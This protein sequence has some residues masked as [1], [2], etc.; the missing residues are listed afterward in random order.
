MEEHGWTNASDLKVGDK[1]RLEDGTTGTVEKAKHVALDNPVTV[2]NFEV[3]DFHTYYVSEQKVLVHN[4]CAATAKNTQVAKSSNNYVYSNDTKALSAPKSKS[5]M[6]GSEGE[7][8]L[9]RLVGGESQKYFSTSI[10]GRF[11]D[12]YADGIAHES[13]VGYTALT[14]RIRTQ[15]EKDAELL[16]NGRIKGTLAFL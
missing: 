6:T 11:V 3:E 13:K 7:E 5:Y 14:K 15:V 9:K 8:E 16:K 2:Y 10:G 1:V 12:Q 4:T